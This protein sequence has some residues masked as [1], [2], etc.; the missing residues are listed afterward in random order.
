MS[1]QKLAMT[2][3]A[4]ALAIGLFYRH[5]SKAAK[6]QDENPSRHGAHA[7]RDL[8]LQGAA[9]GGNAVV[10]SADLN[11]RRNRQPSRSP[12]P[13]EKLPSG[14]TGGGEGAGGSSARRTQFP[15]SSSGQSF[16][17]EK[18]VN[19]S[20]TPSQ[21]PGALEALRGVFSPGG[22]DGVNPVDEGGFRDTRGASKMGSELPS[23]KRAPPA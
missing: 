3:G 5:Q 17:G 14:G 6:K 1:R 15:C 16:G 23:K 20:N 4:G 18:K 8:G 9:V 13:L 19:S 10:G 22:E 2:A 12:A 7:K 21:G 11:A